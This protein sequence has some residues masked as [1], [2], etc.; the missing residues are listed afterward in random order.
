MRAVVARQ[1]G[2][3]EVFELQNL[4]DPQL[5]PGQVL[6]RVKAAGIN[7]ADILSR[8]GLYGGVPKPPFVPGLEISGVIEDVADNLPAQ[9]AG[10]RKGM[11]VAALTK[12]KGYAELVA[13]PASQVFP[14]PDR[15][16]FED[17]AA[18]PVNYLTAY[19]SMFQMGNLQAGDRILIHAAAGGVGVA[20]IQLAKARKLVIFGTAGS[21][22][23][24]YLR[25]IGVHYPID[26]TKEDFVEVVRRAA[27]DGIELAFD[28]VGGDYFKRSQR[29]LGPGGRLVVYGFSAAVGA[30][31][32]RSLWRIAKA[33]LQTRLYHPLPMIDQNLAVIGV[34]LGRMQG[35]EALMK[36][37]MDEIL[38]M[39]EAGEV[40]P[41]IGKSFPLAQA[42]DAHR[43]IHA[44][45]NIGKVLL[46]I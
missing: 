3:P 38:R 37:E 40:K 5:K 4:P 39:Y 12:F 18:I 23:Q 13:V 30:D 2:P 28:A 29:C 14:I 7:F 41:V 16:S 46:T 24:D 25:S 36:K 20:A 26:Y 19:H 34:H 33:L 42:A 31:G 1:Y 32:K 27:P 17:A 9:A 21:A 15:V 44:R 35:R 10:L 43:F 11:R 8:M 6:I 45:Q 22:K